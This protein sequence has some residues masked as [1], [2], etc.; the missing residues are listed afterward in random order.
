M[1]LDVL[2]VEDEPTLLATLGDALED[3]GHAVTRRDD[4]DAAAA[5]LR[6][7]RFDLLVT[8]VR[9]PGTDG[10]ALARQAL[11][12]P[13]PAP[14][15]VLM[16]AYGEVAAAVEMLKLG[17]RDYLLKPFEEDALVALAAHLET[18]RGGRDLAAPVARSAEM[19]QV[20]GLA[21]RVAR[22]DVSVLLTG[23]TGVGKEVVARVVHASSRRAAGPFVAVNC[24]AIPRELIESELFGH[25]RGAFTGAVANR[26]G[27]VR[28]A[29]G[30]TLFLDE[31][32]ELSPEVQARLLRVLE[33]RE[34]APVGT[35]RRQPVDFRLVAA[36][37]RD[38]RD[39]AGG[40]RPDLLYRVAAFEI[41]IPPLRERPADIPALAA[42]FL[43]AL[44]GRFEE[45]PREVTPEAQAALA[46]HP[47]PGNVRE[48][49]NAIEHAAVMAGAAPIRPDHLPPS[50]RD[51]G[52]EA[53]GLDLRA[54]LG[55]VEAEQ[56][57]R[58][59]AVSGGHRSRAAALLGISR[60]HLWELMRR[61][62]IGG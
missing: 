54:A 3:A 51:P 47:W 22:T 34:V 46:S 23:E 19:Q 30:G 17:V 14:D 20:L 27:W 6:R 26:E 39:P 53:A 52:G 1:P 58:A 2:L 35:E 61:H 29:E 48:L 50:I 25:V 7:Q 38:L 57:R 4:G 45:V 44:R 42:H 8:D 59:L 11:A 28:A 15:V 55:R 18:L 43:G 13:P 60:K 41:R 33:T 32:G 40:F 31:I 5:A 37:H 9:L 16:T 36:T 49:R 24:A 56:V 12:S 62:G 10:Y 21:R